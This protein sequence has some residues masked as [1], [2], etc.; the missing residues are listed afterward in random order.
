MDECEQEDPD[1]PWEEQEKGKKFLKW[2]EEY[3]SSVATLRPTV[4]D[5]KCGNQVVSTLPS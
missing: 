4:P 5:V 2:F 3:R 1:T